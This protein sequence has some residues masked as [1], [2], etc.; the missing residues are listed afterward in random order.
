MTSKVKQEVNRLL[1]SSQAASVASAIVGNTDTG[2]L[3]Q[4]L[5]VALRDAV[6]KVKFAENEPLPS[7]DVDA[8]AASAETL[9][10]KRGLK[11][12]SVKVKLSNVR[13]IARCMPVLLGMDTATQSVACVSLD[14]MQ[15]FCTALQSHGFDVR[16]AKAALKKPNG[17]RKETTSATKVLDL[18]KRI[19]K[20][21]GV[22]SGGMA[23][24]IQAAVAKIL[25]KR[26]V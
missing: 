1:T 6:S 4:S 2:T 10:R 11:P 21:K 17:S 7:A 18:A 14:A 22:R 26:G 12:D 25:A 3:A 13:K 9:F 24:E 23:A 5:R 16:K 20:M 8:I 19:T 15:K